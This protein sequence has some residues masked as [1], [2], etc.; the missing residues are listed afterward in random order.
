[1]SAQPQVFISYQR[2]DAT[3]AQWVRESLVAAGGH[4]WMDRYDIPAGAYWP[5]EIDRG[6]VS[7]EI[8]VGIL[9]PDAV[10]SRNVK[11]EW[12]WAIQNGKR[13]LLLQYRS[14]VIPHRYVSLNYID[15]TE[16]NSDA[17]L[18]AL[19]R[20]LGLAAPVPA[21]ALGEP[22]EQRP[23][24]QP[25]RLARRLFS[26]P[27][28]LVGRERE[29]AQLSG[30]L[31]ELLGG[32]GAL[33][34]LGGEAG[35]GKTT[36]TSWLGWSAEER[37]VVALLGGCY[38][39]TITPPYGPWREIIRG[40]PEETLG[41][42]PA[43][44][45]ERDGIT[46]VGSQAAL[47]DL[48]A[49]TF[50]RAAAARPLL[51]VLDDLHWADQASLDLLRFL[52]RT[53]RDARILIVATYRDDEVTRRHPL[54]ALLP[55]LVREA[56]ARQLALARLDEDATRT[57]VKTR[58]GLAESERQALS[59]YLQR[60]AEGNP[61]FTAELLRALEEAGTLVNDGTGWRLERLERV[62]V[63][64]LV[65]LV[66]DSRLARLDDEA[67]RLLQLA[68]VIGHEVPVDLWVTVSGASDEMLAETLEHA[69]EARLVEEVDGGAR[70]RFSHALVR[71]TLYE[72]IVSLRR[73][74]WHRALAETLAADRRPDPDA[75]AYHFQQAG[76]ERA[77]AW[78]VQAGER[79]EY[80]YSW[81]TAVARYE[82]ALPF[83]EADAAARGRLFYRISFL[84]RYVDQE[85]YRQYLAEAFKD[86]EAAGDRALIA[87]CR[88]DQAIGLAV[89][90]D[91]PAGIQA[92]QTSADLFD[93]LT[94][95]ERATL[96]G[97]VNRPGAAVVNDNRGMVILWNIRVADP[98]EVIAEA[99]AFIAAL[100]PDPAAVLIPS[101]TRWIDAYL[102]LAVDEAAVGWPAAAQ[103][104]FA[105]ALAAYERVGDLA[106]AS[107]A[108][109]MGLAAL[110]LPFLT[111]H[112]QERRLLVQQAR[113]AGRLALRLGQWGG[114]NYAE[115]SPGMAA[116]DLIEGRWD[117]GCF[118]TNGRDAG[119]FAL[120]DSIWGAEML[121][122][123]GDP[124]RVITHDRLYFESWGM[125][126]SPYGLR[127][128]AR[129]KAEVAASTR[130]WNL[131]ESWLERLAA[132]PWSASSVAG[133]GELVLAEAIIARERGD[134]PGAEER[135]RQAII[136]A[137]DPRQPLTLMAAQRW[138]G[139]LLLE[140]GRHAE[141][142][143]PLRASLALAHACAAPFELALTQLPLAQQLVATSQVDAAR[144]LLTEA[145]ETCARLK[146]TPTLERV[147]ALE[148][149]IITTDPV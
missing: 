17:A 88:F 99:E 143:E 31:D 63:P 79:A 49:E 96:A 43:A 109:T 38:D 32:Q 50:S 105:G 106:M 93:Q 41:D 55:A 62:Q 81:S 146:A 15:A 87:L 78:L 44:L 34:L 6:L 10:E 97:L 110:Y 116:L 39:L 118:D 18:E 124:H 130:D 134:L 37:G 74:A 83:V 147:A 102:G 3:F 125:M 126:I 98:H 28:E 48:V 9:S 1:M 20:A 12:D 92:M 73:R 42:L 71:E 132:Q 82:A 112:V 77:Y 66:I 89:G 58:Y 129:L 113:E 139:E 135:V 53:L 51:L 40:W 100:P 84:L 121:W 128:M 65:R 131:A 29:R 72:G 59:D 64:N 144:D 19:V 68:A 30:W 75:V 47:F 61:F 108:A 26:A 8:V 120:T 149:K 14:C 148:Q 122:R 140:L 90:D 119:E 114:S 60:S 136:E 5:D 27:T 94:L 25:T 46:R 11:N 76:D 86:A 141:A 35:I 54:A 45:R 145:R 142:E 137:S 70:F 23:R 104:S 67:R 2:A 115:Y 21:R 36:L 24:A 127:R 101:R 4:T 57:L 22:A 33:V 16:L 103:E 13:L 107:G 7:S 111:E 95:A 133:R 138:L 56:G 123:R 117:D 80:S 91:S 85:R 69:S 52:G